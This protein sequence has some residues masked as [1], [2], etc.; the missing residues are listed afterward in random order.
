[1]KVYFKLI[2]I[3]EYKFWC[4]YTYCCYI[5]ILTHVTRWLRILRLW[6][7]ILD[8]VNKHF[9]QEPSNPSHFNNSS[10]A[11]PVW[12]YTDPQNNIHPY[13][14]SAYFIF[15]LYLFF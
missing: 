7:S 1:M 6:L 13:K 12:D 9:T 10:D 11:N 5:I 3:S 15:I 2:D 4:I 14:N 8:G